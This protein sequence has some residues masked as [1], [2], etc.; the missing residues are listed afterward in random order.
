[1]AD[2]PYEIAGGS[3]ER[4]SVQPPRQL[5]ALRL[6]LYALAYTIG[7][8]V[9]MTPI[10]QGAGPTGTLV[11]LLAATLL[12]ALPQALVAA[13][14]AS[15]MPS[16][17]GALVWV[18]R[19]FGPGFGF[20]YAWIQL[21]QFI[22]DISA[23]CALVSQQLRWLGVGGVGSGY[24]LDVGIRLA[25]LALSSC[26]AVL[27]ISQ[28]SRVVAPMM[29]LVAVAVSSG[30]LWATPDFT[31]A[32]FDDERLRADTSIHWAP[33]FTVLVWLFGGVTSVATAGGEA[34]SRTTMLKGL[35]GTCLTMLLLYVMA[36]FVMLA[37]FRSRDDLDSNRSF[38]L[39]AF[40]RVAP[41]FGTP[42]AVLVVI[43][44]G[45]NA[46]TAI[47]SNGRFVWASP[48]LRRPRQSAPSASVSSSSPTNAQIHN[49]AQTRCDLPFPLLAP[50]NTMCHSR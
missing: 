45:L 37:E 33:T 13:E 14:L 21:L 2:A 25:V 16:Q 4:R 39:A 40:S 26:V 1:M 38:F 24:A 9:G 7:A 44:T 12:Y 30:F 32:I 47:V 23:S 29:V 3:S 31:D 18:T 20:Y 46:T 49:S 6:T 43:S 15:V 19:A 41:I 28:L 22:G 34:P 11:G 8:P 42:F 27:S 50:N 5:T 36:L 17:A 10:L 35:T 48:S